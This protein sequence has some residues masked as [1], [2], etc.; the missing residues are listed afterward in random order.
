MTKLMYSDRQLMLVT[1]DEVATKII[2]SSAEQPPASKDTNYVEIAAAAAAIAFRAHPVALALPAVVALAQQAVKMWDQ[3]RKDGLK[4]RMVGKTE[5]SKYNFPPGHPRDGVLYIAHPA[6][7]GAYCCVSD[8]HRIV[9]EH[10]FS[11]AIEI[12]MSL[13]AT[14][15]NVEHIRGWHKDFAASLAAPLPNTKVDVGGSGSY[16]GKSNSHIL[17]KANLS[18]TITPN[19]PSGL[20]WFPHEPTWRSIVNGRLKYGL[21]DFSLS[22]TYDDD[23][24]VNASFKAKAAKIGFDL[25]GKFEDHQATVWRIDGRFAPDIEQ[26]T[27]NVDVK[28]RK[29][30]ISA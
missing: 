5:A 14:E 29:P 4:V 30:A 26:T 18:G 24:G 6:I 9:F 15:V 21:R 12:L 10:K 25:G 16:T 7:D 1:E 8:F 11:E 20:A 28:E 3:A 17:Y 2:E 23:F 19:L 13:G 27:A 22:V